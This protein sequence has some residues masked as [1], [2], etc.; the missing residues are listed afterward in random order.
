MQVIEEQFTRSDKI[1]ASTLIREF[2]T[3]IFDNS[4][5]MRAYIMKMKN[6]F[7]QFKGLNI[8]IFESFFV[9]FIFDALSS[10]Y[11]P[12][13]ISYNTHNKN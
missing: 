2:I 12:F 9:Y 13:K 10:K 4:K 8:E 6:I 3:K 5:S 11:G 7:S 1:L